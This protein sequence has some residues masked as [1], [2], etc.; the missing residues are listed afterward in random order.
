[1]NSPMTARD[2]KTFCVQA[3][4]VSLE[5]TGD[6]GR[7]SG[8]VTSRNKAKMKILVVIANYG[9]KNDGYLRR[10]LEEYRT[11]SHDVHV[12]V[13]TNV[14]KNFGDDVEVVVETPR[15]DPWTFPFAHKKIMAGRLEDFD[16]FV[17]SEDDTLIRG[18]NVDA[19]LSAAEVLEGD[20]I[21]GFLRSE[22]GPDGAT[23]ISTVHSHFHWDPR[24][25]VRRGS[26]TFAY[27]TNE[28]SACYILTRDHLRR[29]IQS[30]GFLAGPHQSGY[31]LLVSAATDPYTRCGFR[32]LICVSKIED[33]VLPHLPNKYVGKLGL[34]RLDF[35]RQIEAL[36]DIGNQK[37]SSTV[38]LNGQTSV[39]RFQWSKSYYE[40][41]SPEVLALIPSSVRRILSFGC[42]WGAPEAE[43]ARKGISVTAV[44]LDSVIGACAE[45]RGIEVV[46]GEP[47]R[48]LE[49]LSGRLFEGILISNLLHLAPEPD[50]LL[51]S[52]SKL[53]SPEGVVIASVPNLAQAPVLLKRMI[54]GSFF[55]SLGSYRRARMHMTSDRKIRHWFA[56][57]GLRVMKMVP[58]I[59]KRGQRLHDLLGGV[60]ER[61]LAS[62]FL[63]V[64]GKP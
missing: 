50:R 60:S 23:Y 62:D 44:P 40:L 43:L 27:F 34:S 46:Y 10:L 15:G 35:L 16:L 9:T 2:R 18:K 56:R 28:H 36:L 63:V 29:A 22:K 55:R 48:A 42:G 30:G 37:R 53:L 47:E 26:H 39:T 5:R 13:L 25:V 61:W 3:A 52:L 24:S 6:C 59:P 12:V 20:E 33:Y 1:M 8:V 45:S 11:M 21:A 31:D 19:F 51:A 38:L 14:R 7:P 4:Q 49:R 32:K 64:G 54:P 58:S 57:A 17:Y 41:L